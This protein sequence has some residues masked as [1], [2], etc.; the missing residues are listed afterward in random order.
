MSRPFLRIC[1]WCP[2][3]CHMSLRQTA[4]LKSLC[5]QDS[6]QSSDAQLACLHAVGLAPSQVPEPVATE[7]PLLVE[8]HS[9][10]P[11]TS[12]PQSAAAYALLA[13]RALSTPAIGDAYFSIQYH[14]HASVQELLLTSCLTLPL[15]IRSLLRSTL[16]ALP[17]LL[18]QINA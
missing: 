8:Q 17:C 15:S 14:T 18:M 16:T 12:R 2:T 7:L 5:I 1:R 10:P 11:P 4:H 9:L 13:C 3:I 6:R